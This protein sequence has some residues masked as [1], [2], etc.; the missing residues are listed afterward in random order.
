VSPPRIDPRSIAPGRRLE[1]ISGDARAVLRAAD[2]AELVV[3]IEQ[4]V[5]VDTPTLPAVVVAGETKRGKSSLVNG[6]LNRKGLSPVDADIATSCFISFV[7]G[8]ADAAVIIRSDEP[9]RVDVSLPELRDWVTVVG[10]P[11]NEKGVRAAYVQAATRSIN[12]YALVD[13]PGVGGLEAGHAALTMQALARADAMI[14]VV[15]AGAPIT[16]PEIEFLEQAAERIDTVLIVLTKVDIYPGYERI[17]EDN[18]ALLARS[19][20]RFAECPWVPVSSRVA[21][22]GLGLDPEV[23][24]Q[25]RTES[26][27][28]VLEQ[29]VIEHVVRRARVLRLTNGARALGSTLEVAEAL[30]AERLSALSG[31]PEMLAALEGEQRHL[32]DINRDGAQWR[33]ELEDGIRLISLDRNEELRLGLGELRTTYIQRVD[34][35]KKADL[36]A[37]PDELLADVAALADQLAQVTAERVL[38]RAIAIFGELDNASPLSRAIGALG[39]S[40]GDFGSVALPGRRTMSLGDHLTAIGSLSTG[41]SIETIIGGAVGGFAFLGP[42]GGIGVGLVFWALRTWGLSSQSKK[43]DLRT[44]IGQEL[45]DAQSQISAMFSRG[46][47]QLQSTLSDAVANHVTQRQEQIAASLAARKRA[48]TE[49]QQERSAERAGLD[50][51]LN[52]IAKLRNR[53]SRLLA[54][55]GSTR[56]AQERL[57]SA[58]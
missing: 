15:D 51:T 33:R 39:D 46:S 6:L 48:L 5:A 34:G 7:S 3:E 38:A 18:R 16:V 36:E 58:G 21:E 56:V 31:S 23:A 49:S 2:L 26:G 17:L 44:W 11:G 22:R 8:P 13:T 19:A 25:I 9:T 20:P 28:S 42:I 45:A 24:A 47:I 12:G 1:L 57:I 50:Q 52:A 54:D 40:S 53:V 14:F 55:L 41:R 29:L 4:A 10:N 37:L 32:A 27:L 35:A 30:V 43:S